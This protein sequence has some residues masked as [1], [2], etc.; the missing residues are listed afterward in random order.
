VV[1]YICFCMMT[2]EFLQLPLEER[3]GYVPKWTEI[4]R[5]QGF[6]LLFWGNV[7]GVPENAVFVFEAPVQTEKYFKFLREWLEL[8]TKDAGKL[9]SYTRTVT[10]N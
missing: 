2:P 3:E 6:N 5:K 1:R 4:A 7:L 8:G 9:I 10:V